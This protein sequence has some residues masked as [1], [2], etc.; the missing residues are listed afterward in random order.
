VIGVVFDVACAILPTSDNFI[1]LFFP[2]GTL[3]TDL[4]SGP[5]LPEPI[6]ISENCESLI[7]FKLLGLAC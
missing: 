1:I 2:N 4:L 7:T 3:M 6:Q 5:S